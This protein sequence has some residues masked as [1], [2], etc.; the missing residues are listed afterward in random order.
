MLA[1]EHGPKASPHFAAG[2]R[3]RHVGRLEWAAFLLSSCL[4]SVSPPL[5]PR[6]CRHLCLAAR[7]DPLRRAAPAAAVCHRRRPRVRAGGSAAAV[8]AAAPAAKPARAWGSSFGTDPR[9]T[10]PPTRQ[11]TH[12]SYNEMDP[13]VTCGTCREL[14]SMHSS[15]PGQLSVWSPPAP[16]P[17]WRDPVLP[18]RSVPPHNALPVRV[19]RHAPRRACGRGMRWSPACAPPPACAR[20]WRPAAWWPTSA[21]GAL[22]NTAVHGAASR[23]ADW[24]ASG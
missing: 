7:H 21:A 22:L 23:A 11:P 19:H 1:N 18:P 17:A 6:P 4:A 15:T 5:L 8:H 14:V 20:P 2:G 12:C 24:Q 13:A 3:R 10:H 16:L 9:P